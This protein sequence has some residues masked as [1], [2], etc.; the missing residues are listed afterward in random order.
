MTK[1]KK[2]Q[3]TLKLR[4]NYI[5]YLTSH[6]LNFH[7]FTSNFFSKI[8]LYTQKINVRNIIHYFVHITEKGMYSLNRVKH[9]IK[10]LLRKKLIILMS[11]F[12]NYDLCKESIAFNLRP[13]YTI[14]FL[15]CRKY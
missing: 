10:F 15:H 11:P 7:I 5:R 12:T 4:R 6:I 1:Q 8:L 3:Q 9:N 2:T 14:L 13:F